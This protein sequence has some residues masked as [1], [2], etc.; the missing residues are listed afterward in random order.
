MNFAETIAVLNRCLN[1]SDYYFASHFTEFK[2]AYKELEAIIL[3]NKSQ[4]VLN[5]IKEILH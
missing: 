1:G 4:S 3:N 2:E 5:E